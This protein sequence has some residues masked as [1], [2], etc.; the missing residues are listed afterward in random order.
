MVEMNALADQVESDSVVY[1]VIAYIEYGFYTLAAVFSTGSVVYHFV[2]R[3][4]PDR[5]VGQEKPEKGK[6][7]S[8]S[9]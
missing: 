5:K 2:R 6:D 4:R 7:D 9:P 8:Y 3:F 1:P